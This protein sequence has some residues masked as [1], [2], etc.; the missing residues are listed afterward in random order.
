MKKCGDELTGRSPVPTPAPLHAPEDRAGR[1]AFEQGRPNGME[2]GG[3][4]ECAREEGVRV[5]GGR[6]ND[7]GIL[8]A[9]PQCVGPPG[10]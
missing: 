4:E 7:R 2:A 6:E 5:E 10:R 8:T 3:R 1:F 9:C